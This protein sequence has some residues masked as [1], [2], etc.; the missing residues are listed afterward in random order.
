VV[1]LRVRFHVIDIIV[2]QQVFSVIL[3]REPKY[4]VMCVCV[5]V[6]CVWVCVCGVCVG[7]WVC[8]CVCGLCVWV[9]GC[10]CV[11]VGVCVDVW[12]VCGGGV[13]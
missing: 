9:W 13:C 2:D 4:C 3:D 11:F 1:R 6:M 8:V 5:C 10:V 12:C 7:V